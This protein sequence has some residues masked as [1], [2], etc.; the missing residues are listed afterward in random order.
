MGSASVTKISQSIIIIQWTHICQK[1]YECSYCSKN[2]SRNIHHIN[3]LY[4][5]RQCTKE[6]GVNYI[7]IR[8]CINTAIV[9]R[10]FHRIVIEFDLTSYLDRLLK[11][12]H[13]MDE[14]DNKYNQKIIQELQN[15]AEID[16]LTKIANEVK[17]EVKDCSKA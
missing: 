7:V 16:T 8:N 17:H 14:Q 11:L 4:Q 1:P 15:R 12:E 6:Y 9:T 2:L 13:I 3:H 10:L 5:C